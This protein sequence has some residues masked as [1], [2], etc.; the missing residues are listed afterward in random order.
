MIL[1][2]QLIYF[3]NSNINSNNNIIYGIQNKISYFTINVKN[4]NI[5]LMAF[6]NIDMICGHLK[7]FYMAGSC[8]VTA[9]FEIFV[10]IYDRSNQKLRWFISMYSVCFDF[11]WRVLVFIPELSRTVDEHKWC[12][13]ESFC[14]TPGLSMWCS[15]SECS[16]SLY[17]WFPRAKVLQCS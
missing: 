14:T 17:P 13:L 6:C 12:E 4:A 10:M 3:S 9:Q 1:F 8:T 15:N 5:W 2:L 7:T 11:K 16:V